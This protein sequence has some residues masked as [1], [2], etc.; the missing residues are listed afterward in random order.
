[1]ETQK[2]MKMTAMRTI[3]SFKLVCS[4]CG[5]ALEAESDNKKSK[6]NSTGYDNLEA[7][8]AIK[9]YGKCD[10][11]MRESLNQMAEALKK[12]TGSA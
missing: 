9:P 8:M 12:I 10:A 2:E 4:V 1:M 6:F 5:S 11:E 7:I 3:L